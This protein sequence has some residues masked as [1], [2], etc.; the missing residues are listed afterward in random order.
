[1]IIYNK[2]TKETYN[3]FFLEIILANYYKFVC[4]LL[5]YNNY[6]ML[7]YSRKILKISHWN[8]NF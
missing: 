2:I 5:R 6:S 7:Y 3:E 1:M 4:I 8:I